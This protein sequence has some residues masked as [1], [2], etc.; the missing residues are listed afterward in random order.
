MADTRSADLR[1]VHALSLGQ[2]LL[3]EQSEKSLD[4]LVLLNCSPLLRLSVLQIVLHAAID[5]V[6]GGVSTAWGCHA[7]S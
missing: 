3:T 1:C 4:P 5:A 6:F 2:E 7:C